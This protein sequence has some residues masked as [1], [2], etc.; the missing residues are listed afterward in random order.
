MEWTKEDL[1]LLGQKPPDRSSQFSACYPIISLTSPALAAS[2]PRTLVLASPW[3]SVRSED[4]GVFPVISNKDGQMGP[5]ARL[6]ER[7]FF[8]TGILKDPPYFLWLN[9]LWPLHMHI[10]CQGEE[11]CNGSQRSEPKSAPAN[12]TL[13]L[14]HLL[15]SILHPTWGVGLEAS[16]HIKCPSSFKLHPCKNALPDKVS[17]L[18]SVGRAAL[19]SGEGSLTTIVWRE[20]PNSWQK[21]PAGGMGREATLFS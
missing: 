17:S 10:S 2:G 16:F 19:C 18:L 21:T 12:E 20:F 14:L 3:P 11:N 13:L 5:R 6:V 9:E 8:I 7:V 15:N 1:L 4:H